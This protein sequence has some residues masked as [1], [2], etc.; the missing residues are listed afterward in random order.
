[1]TPRQAMELAI[2]EA[3]KG[4][5]HV[6]PNPPVGAVILDRTG[7]LLSVAHHTRYGLPHAEAEAI[8]KVR[9]KKQLKKAHLFV[10]LEPC[11]HQGKTPPC[12]EAICRFGLQSVTYGAEDPF[13]QKK[14]IRFLRRQGI[15]CIA[16]PWFQEELEDLVS[17]FTWSFRHRQSAVGLKV[18]SSLDGVIAPL[19]GKQPPPVWITSLKTRKKARIL[20]TR[21]AATL[22]GVNTLLQDNPQLNIRQKGY[23]QTNKV[24]VLD[25]EGKSFS[26]LRQSRLV[27]AHSKE[28]ILVVTAKAVVPT[29][30]KKDARVFSF[31]RV[32]ANSGFAGQKVFSL[33][34]LMKVLYRE[35]HI[36]SVLVEGGA[37]TLCRFLEQKVGEKLYLYLAPVILGRGLHWSEY[38][39]PS[40]KKI[41]MD[42]IKWYKNA[43]DMLLEGSL[44][45][46]KQKGRKAF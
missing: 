10:T 19:K 11:H 21:Y 39:K 14:G 24:I 44:S 41:V 27:K 9:D 2:Q 17:L 33:S 3:K 25:P 42:K 38:L 22:V 16:S 8:R 12:T 43:P 1:M 23:P 5:G 20:R 35:H 15:S 37:W 32:L 7:D 28:D 30:V 6:E 18:A 34:A 31:N 26:F 29:S 40:L 46:K 13:T 36:Q 4:L 45:F